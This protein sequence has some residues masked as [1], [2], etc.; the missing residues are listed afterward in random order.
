[1]S[2]TGLGWQGGAGSTSSCSGDT[3]MPVTFPGRPL[4]KLLSVTAFQKVDGNCGTDGRPLEI[5]A[6]VNVIWL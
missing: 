4:G 3:G 5:L 6:R 1:M 2:C